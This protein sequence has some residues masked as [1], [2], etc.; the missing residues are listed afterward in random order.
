MNSRTTYRPSNYRLHQRGAALALWSLVIAV[1]LLH[2][3]RLL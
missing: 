2:L 1:N 3:A